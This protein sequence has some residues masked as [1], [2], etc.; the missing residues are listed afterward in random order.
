MKQDKKGFTLV[1]IMIVVAIIVSA[2]G[3]S[4]GKSCAQPTMKSEHL[5][6]LFHGTHSRPP[7]RTSPILTTTRRQL[8]NSNALASAMA[9]LVGTNAYIKDTPVCKGGGTYTL[10]TTLA[11]K[12]SCSVHG[13][14]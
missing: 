10:P 7:D 6:F 12:T 4:A 5:I 9:Q 8:D 13:P 2:R 1:E 3:L 11:A 14:F